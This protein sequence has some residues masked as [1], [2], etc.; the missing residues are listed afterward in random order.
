MKK[1]I[2]IKPLIVAV[3][4]L[5][6]LAVAVTL[7]FANGAFK[8]SADDAPKEL[9]TGKY[10]GSADGSKYIEVFEDKTIQIFGSNLYEETVNLPENKEVL[11]AM[12][13]EER[14]E[15][16]LDIKGQEEKLKMRHSYFILDGT[17]IIV[18][19]NEKGESIG[20]AFNYIDKNTIQGSE[21]NFV[22]AK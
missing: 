5:A 3:S 8:S 16:D 1:T 12:S 9:K 11:A 13:K 20:I 6:G 7:L 18:L 15:F 21:D 14:A 19:A 4:A 17:D 10:I 2:K 22:Y